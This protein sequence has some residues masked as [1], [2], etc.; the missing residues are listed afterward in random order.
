[1]QESKQR[2]VLITGAT[3]MQ[4]RPTVMAT[5]ERG[6]AVRVLAR[7]PSSDAAQSL[8][9]KGVELV[10]GSFEDPAS[11][12]RAMDGVRGVFSL[13][14]AAPNTSMAQQ[15]A[16]LNAAIKAGVDQFVQSTVSSTGLHESF[17]RWN[18]ERWD[19]WYW[20][21]KHQQEENV[22]NAGFKYYT[23]VRPAML[24]D[25]FLPYRA[26]FMQS[27]LLKTGEIVA[28]V[29]VDTP[30]AYVS[31]QTVGLASAV[32]FEDPARFHGVA[33]ELAD[34]MISHAQIA[35]ILSDVTGKPV[36]AIYKSEE[37]LAAAG[38]FSGLV[39]SQAWLD[40][41]GYAARPAMLADYGLTPISFQHW[42]A[43]HRGDFQ[44]GSPS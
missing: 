28:A 38:V 7:D 17:S 29:Q 37:E 15:E 12:D 35:S 27:D 22:R 6:I 36:R 25:N 16:L 13:Q 21:E 32:A 34:D 24:M 11:L 10:Q 33:M 14:L 30:I 18:E 19:A 9:A 2:P 41:V 3:G 8:A 1:V 39:R 26:Q 31:S 44:V 43:T 42:A 4:G 5:M 40:A 20:L 23:M